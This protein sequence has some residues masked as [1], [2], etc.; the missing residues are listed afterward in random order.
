MNHSD[1][2]Q[3][4]ELI[5]ASEVFT[6]IRHWLGSLDF[7]CFQY[8]KKKP[9]QAP[10][11]TIL[12]KCFDTILY[13]TMKRY[14]SGVNFFHFCCYWHYSQIYQAHH[15]NRIKWSFD[16]L[17]ICLL[18]QRIRNS[19]TTKAHKYYG[20]RVSSNS[21]TSVLEMLLYHPLAICSCKENST[22]FDVLST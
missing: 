11:L 15:H 13:C 22:N 17:E 16:L 20:I 18:L 1:P 21:F 2:Q 10:T 14:S 3:M 19:V 9:F 4:L 6:I 5:A 7:D 8:W 12:F